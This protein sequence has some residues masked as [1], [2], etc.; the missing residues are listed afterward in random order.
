[1]KTHCFVALLTIVALTS[2]RSL[3]DTGS[4][5][6]FLPSHRHLTNGI[7]NKYYY[8]FKD[9]ED[10]NYRTNILYYAYQLKGDGQLTIS[11]YDAAFKPILEM[12]LSYEKDSAQLLEYFRYFNGRKIR[13]EPGEK[14]YIKWFEGVARSSFSLDYGQGIQQEISIL[15]VRIQDTLIEG[16]T[17]ARFTVE[18]QIETLRDGQAPQERNFKMRESYAPGIGLWSYQTENDGS[19]AQLELVEQMS[20]NT[21]R[22]RSNHGLHRIAYIDSSMSLTKD[23]DFSICQQHSAIYDYYNGEPDAGM[24]GGKPALH[25]L[26]TERLNA[27][28]FGW[29]SGYLTFR[30]VINCEGRA[31]WFTTEEADLDFQPSSFS[32][33]TRHSLLQLLLK[34]EQWRSCRIRGEAVDAY[35]YVTFKLKDGEIIELLP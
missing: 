13:A 10:Y 3:P 12:Q 7:V 17:M 6:S 8:H 23:L 2:C 18:Q 33:E 34:I 19:S 35:F 24:I 20:M 27:R 21:F 30:F 26:L 5:D 16:R 28:T 31:G 29:E 15:R 14:G 1:M 32:E 22:E 11:R 9:A 25:K 4:R